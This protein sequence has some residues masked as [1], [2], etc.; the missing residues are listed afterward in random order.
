MSSTALSAIRLANT[1]AVIGA[2]DAHG[3]MSRAQL[4]TATGLSRTTTHAILRELMDD[5]VVIEGPATPLGGPGRPERRLR[6]DP[7]AGVVM[8]IELGRS[9]AAAVVLNWSGVVLWSSTTAVDDPLDWDASV[10]ILMELVGRATAPPRAGTNKLRHALVGLPGLMPSSPHHVGTDERDRRIADVRSRL[11]ESLGV[12]V[13]VTGNTRL[14]A[15][16]EFRGRGLAQE[17]LIYCH[18]SRGVGAAIVLG[19]HLLR[20]ATNSAGEFGHMR[21]TDDGPPCHCGSHGCLETLVGTDRVL[22]QARDVRPDLQDFDD[23]CRRTATDPALRRL[24]EDTARTLGR[25]V[26]NMCNIIN[27]EHVVLGGD[28]VRLTDDWDVLVAAG[29]DDTALGQVQEGMSLST[30]LHGRQAASHGAGLLA[31][32]HILGRANL[33]ESDGSHD[34]THH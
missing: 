1:R 24:A 20:G 6:L 22:A 3:G 10:A 5:G 13:G 9:Q 16:A 18:L 26:G 28:L 4:C 11:T 12:P 17:T 29:L 31:L 15:V 21:T 23:L 19:G 34:P 25:A 33:L 2:L 14:A 27:P 7:G 30:S 8:G 32:D